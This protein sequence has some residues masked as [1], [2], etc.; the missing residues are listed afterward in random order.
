MTDQK[1]RDYFQENVLPILDSWDRMHY[2]ESITQNR[3]VTELIAHLNKKYRL[4]VE[5]K[6]M[7]PGVPI[8]FL[9]S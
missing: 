6:E 9:D 7:I 5:G 4:C 3:D 8:D 2:I 1:A